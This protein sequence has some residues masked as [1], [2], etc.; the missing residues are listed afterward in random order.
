MTVKLHSL[1]RWNVLAPKAAVV[2]DNS[3]GSGDRRVRLNLNL[4]KQTTLYVEDSNG[5]RLLVTAGPGLETVEFA[6]PGKV[7]VFAEDGAAEVHYQTAETEP[8]FVSVVDPVIFTKI[9][10]R[11]HRNPELEEMMHRMQANLERRLAL[12]S[13]EIEA[14]FERRRQEEEHGRSAEVIKTNAPG[15]AANNSPGEVRPP[16]PASPASGENAGSEADGEPAGNA[17]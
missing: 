8:T 7:A 12:Q 5:P 9:A 14:A 4:A 3:S 6:A 15:A 1:D 2:F 13:S 16:E 10:N 17:A 11:R